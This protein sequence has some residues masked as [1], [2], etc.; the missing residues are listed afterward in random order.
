MILHCDMDAFYASVE[1]RDQP[2]LVGHP[3]IVGGSPEKRGVVAAANYVARKYGVHSAMP[4]AT[5]H[6]LCPQGIFLWPRIGYYAEISVQSREI[7]GRFTPLVEPLSLD[8]AFLDVTG[9]ETLW[10]SSRNRQADQ[11][12][13]PPGDPAGGFGRRGPQQVPGQDR[14]RP[15]EARR[16]GCGRAGERFK[17]S[18]I[19][20]PWSGSG[21][22]VNRGARSSSG[23]ASVP[24]GSFASGR[25]TPSR[26]DSDQVVS[27]SGNWRTG[28]TTGQS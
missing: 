26:P 10:F 20:C 5:A 23:W 19:R 8:E 3:V 13:C 14:Q 12:D 27:T 4:A 15:Q 21:V 11:G 16:L 9:S 22:S 7:F 17:N 18:L 25:W 6:R 24:S 28:S 2:E 1:E